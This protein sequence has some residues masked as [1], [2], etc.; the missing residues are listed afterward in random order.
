M[1]KIFGLFAMAAVAA[2]G[3]TCC[4]GGGGNDNLAYRT[5]QFD[6]CTGF[7]GCMNVAIFD[8]NGMNEGEYSAKVSFGNNH[9]MG[10]SGYDATFKIKDDSDP[11]NIQVTISVKEKDLGADEDAWAYFSEFMDD[12][13]EGDT[14]INFP[15]PQITIHFNSKRTGGTYDTLYEL[16]GFG[17]DPRTEDEEEGPEHQFVITYG[18]L[19]GDFRQIN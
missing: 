3:L 10:A 16:H 4:G 14:M 18:P 8:L 13:E 9:P 12:M 6:A 2:T 11:E 7:I 5:Y 1:K 15:K 19:T 17:D